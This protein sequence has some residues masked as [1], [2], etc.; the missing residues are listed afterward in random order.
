MGRGRAVSPDPQGPS[1]LTDLLRRKVALLG[2]LARLLERE[3]GALAAAG[4]EPVMTLADE[5]Q[6]LSARLAELSD[7]LNEA[8]Q[9]SGY[10]ADATGLAR[11][12]AEAA[13]GGELQRLYEQA[14]LSLQACARHNQTNGGLVERRRSATERALRIFFDGT[15]D[16]SRYHPTGRLEGLSPNRLIGSA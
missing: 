2:E 11:C 12:I 15:S 9:R 6:R 13:D 16:A 4:H 1:D 14:M 5:K 3:T 8:L 10:E 7:A